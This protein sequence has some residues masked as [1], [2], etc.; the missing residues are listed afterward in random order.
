MSSQVL[1]NFGLEK[2]TGRS[3]MNSVFA[4]LLSRMKEKTLL[5]DL[6]PSMVSTKILSKTYKTVINTDNTIYTGLNN[7]DLQSSVVKLN[8]LLSLIPG[9]WRISLWNTLTS[10]NVDSSKSLSS[11]IDKFKYKFKYIIVDM[12]HVESLVLNNG[13]DISTNIFLTLENQKSS[14]ISFTDDIKYL[15]NNKKNHQ[16]TYDVSGVILYFNRGNPSS[17]DNQVFLNDA[18]EKFGDAIL[19]NPLWY[20]ERVKNF[21]ASG[22][23]S[24]GVW[25]NRVLTMYQNI[26]NEEL[27]R[28]ED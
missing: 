11:C 23:S 26:L 19:S 20:Q 4:F 1:V 10:S 8:D 21:T 15:T 14:Y 12:P 13:L 22:I 16:T 18:R 27:T 9:D 24:N 6:D 5:I 3:T 2:N 25:D 28:I 17:K 7:N